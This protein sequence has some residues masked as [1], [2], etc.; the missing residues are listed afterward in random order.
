MY[1]IAIIGGETHIGEVTSLRDKSLEVAA[2][3]VRPEQVSWAEQV[4]GAPV[5][6]DFREMLDAVPV[7]IVAVANENDRKAEV[8][9]EALRRGK[10]VI[11]DKPMALHLEEVDAIERL[12]EEGGRRVLMLLTLRGNPWYRKVRSL[13]Q[14]GVIGEPMQVYGKM[15]VELKRD[16]RPAWFLDKDRAGGPILDLAIHTIDQVEWVTGLKLAEV[17]A[18]EAN[19]SEPSDPKLIDSGAMFF[20]MSNGGTAVIEHNRVMPPGTGSDYR[21]DVVGTKGM[22]NLRFGTSLTVLTQEGQHQVP[23]AELGEP[24]S[25]VADW[26]YSLSGGKAAL[27]PDAASY[28]ANRVACLAK[29]AADSGKTLQLG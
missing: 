9:L 23:A 7:D 8:I 22:V 20:R 28:R 3:A 10:H 27:V 11:V 25:V 14:S 6:S 16:Q 18:Y 15:S 4:F 12:A 2:V 21:L 17:T 5:Y 29:M 1:R 19:I 13:A 24:V 26:L